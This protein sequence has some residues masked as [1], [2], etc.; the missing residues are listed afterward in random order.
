MTLLP[1]IGNLKLFSHSANCIWLSKCF[2]RDGPFG[3]IRKRHFNKN[4]VAG[5]VPLYLCSFSSRFGIRWPVITFP[6]SERD[7]PGESSEEDVRTV[8]FERQ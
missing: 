7:L 8:P 4:Y 3:V 2:R 5:V 6:E 1:S